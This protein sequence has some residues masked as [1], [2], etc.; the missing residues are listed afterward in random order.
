MCMNVYSSFN[1]YQDQETTQISFSGWAD[2][3]WT[4]HTLEFYSEIFKQSKMF[5]HMWTCMKLKRILRSEAQTQ[6]SILY[7]IPFIKQSVKRWNVEMENR[8]VWPECER[9]GRGLVLAC[10]TGELLVMTLFCKIRS[11]WIHPYAFVNPIELDITKD[12]F[13][14]IQNDNN[15]NN[16]KNKM[17]E[18]PRV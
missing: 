7:V 1:H 3:L 12:K 13:N 16:N 11:L 2:K 15:K 9:Y 17:S 4:I 14:C 8:S 10:H 18:D 6:K 5:P